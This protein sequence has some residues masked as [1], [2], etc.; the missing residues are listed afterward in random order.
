MVEHLIF[1]AAMTI[2]LAMLYAY[3]RK[4]IVKY[5]GIG[6]LAIFLDLIWDPIGMSFGLWRYASQPQIFGMS[7]Y[8]LLLYVH[9]LSFS[10]FL[11]NK[12]N[13]WVVKRWK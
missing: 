13:E 9:Y 3:D 5:L 11:G 12:T 1:F 4:N 10:Y 7:V 8:M 2:P 6:I